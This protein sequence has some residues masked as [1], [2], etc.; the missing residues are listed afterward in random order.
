MVSYVLVAF[1]GLAVAYSVH[2]YRCFATNLAVAKQSGFPIIAG[3]IYNFNTFWLVTHRL[4]LPLFKRLPKAWIEPWIEFMTPDWVWTKLYDAF[5][6]RDVDAFILVSPGRNTL[7]VADAE[8]INQITTRRND[9]PKPIEIYRS[10]D[11]FGKNVVSTEGQ[12]WRHHRKITSPPFTERNNHLVWQES[13]HQAQEMMTGWMGTSDAV[14][15][16]LYDVSDQAMRLSLHV[17]SRAGFGQ[18]LTWPHEEPDQIVPEGHT[19]TYKD[20]LQ[21][22]L[23]N[24]ITVMLTPRWLL[25]NS[26]LKLHKVAQE[27]FVEWGK[28]MREMYHTK[29]DEVASG[30]TREG[31][32]LMGALVKG[33]G[34][35]PESLEKSKADPSQS[36]QLLTDDEILGNAF[37]F[38]LAGH[39]TAANTIHF[40]ALFLAMNPASQRHLQADLDSILGDRPS[41]EWDYDEDMSKLFAGMCGAVMNEQLRLIPPVVGIPKSTAKDSPQGLQIGG[42]HYTVPGDCYL[43]LETAAV[44]RNPK[45]W[46]HT[47]DEDLL[48]FRPER[49]LLD[50]DTNGLSTKAQHNDGYA[51]EEDLDF[52]GPDKRAD[53][54]ASMFTPKKGA[55]IPFSDGYR[56]CLG[57]RFAQ[58]EILAVLAVVFKNFTVELD[59][60]GFLAEGE[61]E[62]SMSEERRQALWQKAKDKANYLLRNG[63]MTV[64]TIQMRGEKVPLRFRRREVKK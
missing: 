47:S 51:S 12:I 64:I 17:I 55:Y 33:A 16:S 41:S 32:D 38:I 52:D 45:Y 49:W 11:I 23:E 10:V 19:L 53:T 21:N 8:A 2:T 15:K 42:K 40:S 5:R 58:I 34:I 54:A 36:T 18:R 57:R 7:D 37:V 59:I 4:W 22:L 43:T 61:T 35:T 39:E 31:M 50:N 28:Y 29:R 56:S 13:L 6:D 25:A 3:P 27:S 20:A 14:S 9:F 48:E 62:E 63:M 44:H 30:E 26:P 60:S 24:V 1:V 46:P